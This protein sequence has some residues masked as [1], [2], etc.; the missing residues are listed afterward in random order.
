MHCQCRQILAPSGVLPEKPNFKTP[1][2][3]PKKAMSQQAV[4]VRRRKTA[5]E[6]KADRKG[7]RTDPVDVSVNVAKL[8][9]NGSWEEPGFVSRGYYMD[10]PF[11]CRDCRQE[12]VWTASQQKW[13]YEIAGGPLFTEASRCRV[14]RRKERKRREEA[15]RVHP[16]GLKAKGRTAEIKRWGTSWQKLRQVY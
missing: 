7:L 1:T 10:R 5:A 4:K 8:A 14:C 15:R 11:T 6:R 3:K 13:W 12:Q 9:P 16:E 2:V